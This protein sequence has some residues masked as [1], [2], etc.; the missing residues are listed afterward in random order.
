MAITANAEF[1]CIEDGEMFATAGVFVNVYADD[2]E[3][4]YQ[5]IEKTTSG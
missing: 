4:I 5:G 1:V 3:L 2:H